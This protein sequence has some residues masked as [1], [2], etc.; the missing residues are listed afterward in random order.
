MD[1]VPVG[2]I[3]NRLTAD[4]D[5]LDS[6]LME[7]MTL[8]LVHSFELVTIYLPGSHHSLSGDAAA[9]FAAHYRQYYCLATIFGSDK[10]SEAPR[11]QCQISSL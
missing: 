7:D 9:S 5:I 3:L 10:T 1:T 8:V 4:F 6:R 11:E 2:R